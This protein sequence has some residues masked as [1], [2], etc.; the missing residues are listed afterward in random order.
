MRNIIRLGLC[1]L[2]VTGLGLAPRAQIKALTLDEMVLTADQAVSGQI[3][4][5][6][7][8][9]V[10]SKQAGSELYYTTLTIQGAGLYDSRPLSVDVTFR[11]GFINA[12]EGVFNSEAPAA[13]DVKVGRHV[14]AFYRWSDDMGGSVPGNTLVAAHGGLYRVVEGPRG[15]TVLGRGEGYA[16]RANLRVEQL[17]S[18]V[19]LLAARKPLR[20]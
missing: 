4:S 17:R 14:V 8:F 19:R 15:A 12:T 1:S 10:D 7:V 16:V 6:R 11:G 18:G 2:L 3:V 13:D 20:R 5:S 9:R